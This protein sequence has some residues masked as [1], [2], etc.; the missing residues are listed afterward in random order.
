MVVLGGG[1]A[2]SYERGTTAFA[3]GG[4]EEDEEDGSGSEDEVPL[5]KLIAPLTSEHGT[6][7]TAK[8]RFWPWRSGNSLLE[9]SRRSFGSELFPLRKVTTPHPRTPS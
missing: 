5:P 9:L 3:V 2:V 8:A 4:S 1:G 7:K 6:Y